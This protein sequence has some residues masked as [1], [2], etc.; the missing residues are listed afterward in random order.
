VQGSGLLTEGLAWYSAFLVVRERYGQA[1]PDRLLEWMHGTDMAPS[2]RAGDALLRADTKLAY[3]RTG[4]FALYRLSEH[5]GEPSVNAALRRMLRKH[6]PGK[7]PMATSLDLYRE[8][9]A[10]T[11]DSVKPLLHDLFAA[12]T[13]WELA[14]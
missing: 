2:S 11:P 6:K 12:N 4:P 5:I 1:T 8:L 14:V 9:D 3:Y 7:V 13:F 10:L